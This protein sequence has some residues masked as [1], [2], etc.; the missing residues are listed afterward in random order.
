MHVSLID[1]IIIIIFIALGTQ[2]P[3]ATKLIQIVKL[4]VCLG[5]SKNWAGTQ[6][7]ERKAE[8]EWIEALNCYR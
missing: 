4:Y 7:P 3:R 1:I 5:W 6:T 2:F 8:A